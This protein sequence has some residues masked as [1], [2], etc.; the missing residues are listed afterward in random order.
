MWKQQ[1]VPKN[2]KRVSKKHIFYTLN[3]NTYLEVYKTSWLN[4]MGK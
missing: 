3:K 1:A 2:D 4:H